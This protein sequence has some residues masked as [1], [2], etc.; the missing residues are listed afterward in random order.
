MPI[1]STGVY[2]A[3]LLTLLSQALSTILSMFT[4]LIKDSESI[5]PTY[6]LSGSSSMAA[7]ALNDLFSYSAYLLLFLCITLLVRDRH[8]ALHSPSM[9]I[10]AR[11][12]ALFVFLGASGIAATGFS[13]GFI[14]AIFQ[15]VT[16]INESPSTIDHNA[17]LWF[18]LACTLDLVY[19]FA[20][21]SVVGYSIYAYKEMKRLS[22]NDMVCSLLPS[23]H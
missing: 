8:L 3:L 18:N 5:P 16:M 11:Y 9:A 6:S 13:I 19:Y 4:T 21:A 20:S 22:L 1:R 12:Y 17:S 2:F 23:N 10:P 15:A 14:R 7:T